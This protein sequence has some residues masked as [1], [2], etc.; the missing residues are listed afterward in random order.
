ME[1]AFRTLIVMVL[2]I[3]FALIVIALAANFFQNGKLSFDGLWDWFQGFTKAFS[4][5]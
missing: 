5:T 2:A 3:I 4:P 1:F